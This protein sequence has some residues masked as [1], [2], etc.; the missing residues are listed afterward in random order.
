MDVLVSAVNTFQKLCLL[1]NGE[2]WPIS[3]F[4][5]DDGDEC[6][7]EDAAFAIVG[8]CLHPDEGEYWFSLDLSDFEDAATH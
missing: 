5:D 7:E 4:L 2:V 6:G 1:E 8:P 3:D